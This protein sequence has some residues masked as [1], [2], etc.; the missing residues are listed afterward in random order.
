MPDQP[1]Q[2]LTPGPWCWADF[3]SGPTLVTAHSGSKVIL[4]AVPAR[5][6]ALQ[7]VLMQRG[8]HGFLVPIDTNHPDMRAIAAASELRSACDLA[9]KA[10]LLH[11]EGDEYFM[12]E[13]D[14]VA[15]A[16]RAVIRKV[17]G[18]IHVG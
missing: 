2:E 14:E 8:P 13:R 12:D 18:E 11:V 4:S 10:R 9:F 3:G 16:L 5:P 7:P 1:T 6:G 15:V 17:K